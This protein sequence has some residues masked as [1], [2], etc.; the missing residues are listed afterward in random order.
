[1]RWACRALGGRGGLAAAGLT[2]TGGTRLAG[3][4]GLA[5]GLRLATGGLTGKAGGVVA[6]VV[7]GVMGIGCWATNPLDS[8]DDVEGGVIVVEMAS[9]FFD[10]MG[11]VDDDRWKGRIKKLRRF[12][13]GFPLTVAVVDLT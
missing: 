9:G 1:M 10:V 8:T 7:I 3:G 11:G 4:D 2:A 6:I 12:D 5:V 13:S